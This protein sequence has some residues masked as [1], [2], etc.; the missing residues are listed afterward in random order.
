M[1]KHVCPVCETVYAQRGILEVEIKT[2]SLEYECWQCPSCSYKFVSLTD[3]QEII[4]KLK[5]ENPPKL[6]FRVVAESVR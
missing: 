1:G 3:I 5:V 6:R 2:L 4:S